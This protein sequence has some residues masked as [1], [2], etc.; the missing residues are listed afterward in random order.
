MNLVKGKV[1]P[2]GHGKLHLENITEELTL[3][4][5][6]HM[7]TSVLSMKR[8]HLLGPHPNGR[9]SGL[10]QRQLGAQ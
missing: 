5:E 6:N 8:E 7:V 4:P 2:V 3:S 10:M 9:D 1:C